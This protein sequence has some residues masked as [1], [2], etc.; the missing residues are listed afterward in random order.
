LLVPPGSGFFVFNSNGSWSYIS[1]IPFTGIVTATYQISDGNGNTDTATLEITVN[2]GT[3]SDGVQNGLETGVDCGGSCTPCESCFDGVQNQ[4]EIGVDCGGVCAAC[5]GCVL[6]NKVK[7]CSNAD[8][9]GQ[10][11]FGGLCVPGGQPGNFACACDTANCFVARSANSESFCELACACAEDCDGAGTCLGLP[12][13]TCVFCS[14]SL[15]DAGFTGCPAGSTC[16]GKYCI[17]ADIC[18]AR[19]GQVRLL[20]MRRGGGGIA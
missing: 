8:C 19:K 2:A 3:C 20:V 15:L 10:E 17:P 7:C 12:D 9:T 16:D 18:T 5:A 14:A 4:D 6:T 1:S 13:Q 11:P